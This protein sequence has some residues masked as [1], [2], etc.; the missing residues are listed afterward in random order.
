MTRTNPTTLTTGAIVHGF[1]KFFKTDKGFG[2]ATVWTGT[3]S[4]DVFLRKETACLLNGTHQAGF[5]LTNDSV[6]CTAHNFRRETGVVIEL[7]PS[8]KG[9]WQA[10]RWGIEPEF[11]WIDLNLNYP[12]RLQKL[13]G[14]YVELDN[15]SNYGVGGY[16]ARI[17]QLE[18]THE[19]LTVTAT[20]CPREWRPGDK[21]RED[22]RS[23]TRVYT[24]AP[25]KCVEREGFLELTWR[26]QESY[27]RLT[28]RAPR[29]R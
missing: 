10:R 1:V 6:D 22:A 26:D 25:V 12:E 9:G 29:G 4:V 5:T 19:S 28:L 24:L 14:G 8:R 15:R 18:L 21:L 17:D 11:T 3:D 27:N 23:F 7:E 16:T 2:F 20:H 13:V